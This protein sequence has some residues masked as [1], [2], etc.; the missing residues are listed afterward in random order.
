MDVLLIEEESD[1]GRVAPKGVG[2]LPMDGGAP[3]V[4]AAIENA[5]GRSASALPVT[6]E[7]VSVAPAVT[8]PGAVAMGG[9]MG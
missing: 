6:P 8:S 1:R 2:E 7:R 4:A 9:G 5:T 3:A